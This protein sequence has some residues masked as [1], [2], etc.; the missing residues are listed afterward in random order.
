MFDHLTRSLKRVWGPWLGVLLS[1]GLTTVSLVQASES[2][3]NV[4][5]VKSID[6]PIYDEVVDSLAR[7]LLKEDCE[8]DCDA[9]NLTAITRH[10][11]LVMLEMPAADLVIP[12]GRLAGL[13]VAE[14][15]PDAAIYGLIPETTW[16]EIITCCP[17]ARHPQATVLFLDQPITRQLN[18]IKVILPAVTRVA[19]LFGNNSIHQRD[20]VQAEAKR[21]GIELVSR[22]I[23]E[24]SEVGPALDRMLDNVDAL[25]A[26]PDPGVYNR[27]TI[28]GVLLTT[29]RKGIPVFG[30][31]KSLVDAGAVAA[32]Y[33][34]P[35]DVGR[36]LAEMANDYLRAH[37]P[38]PAPLM[39][40]RFRVAINERVMRSLGMPILQE[41][42]VRRRLMELEP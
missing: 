31:A 37:D 13:S 26:L 20:H 36:Q 19:V 32:I 3:R 11:M 17:S 10:E 23:E 42:E 39:P 24:D 40:E 9:I 15:A 38:L 34:S 7:T 12:I 28:Y 22:S 8:P 27:D 2:V 35:Q 5:V 14:S 29:Y 41:D 25:L 6:A 1:A 33:T 30:Y 18:L 4:L 16:D 21:L